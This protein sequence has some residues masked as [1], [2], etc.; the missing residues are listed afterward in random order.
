MLIHRPD[1]A[2]PS[3]HLLAYLF[4]GQTF[5]PVARLAL[6]ETHAELARAELQ[7][8]VNGSN[9]LLRTVLTLDAEGLR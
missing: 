8:I 4:D 6:S 1:G 7:D 5:Q 3:R 9:V 2:P